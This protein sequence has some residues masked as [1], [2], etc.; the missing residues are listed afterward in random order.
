M[1]GWHEDFELESRRMGETMRIRTIETLS[2]NG[3]AT[4]GVPVRFGG[5]LKIVSHETPE[6]VYL[7]TTGE[8]E[9]PYPADLLLV[10]EVELGNLNRNL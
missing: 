9:G 1:Q 8:P 2:E 10:D 4:R 6:G 3:F 7:E 5:E